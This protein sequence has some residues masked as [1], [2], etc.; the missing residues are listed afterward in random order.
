MAISV[1]KYV[2]ITS[3]VGAGATVAAKDLILRVYTSNTGG[4]VLGDGTS[5]TV[6]VVDVESL[7]EAET[8]FTASSDEY[9][10]ASSYF[11]FKSKFIVSPKKIQFGW[12]EDEAT[13]PD[14]A[15]AITELTAAVEY[16]NNFATF[17]FVEYKSLAYITALAQWNYDTYGNEYHY[18]VA[19]DKTDGTTDVPTA[20]AALGGIGSC[21]F[22]VVDRLAAGPSEDEWDEFFPGAV[23]AATNYNRPNAVNNFMFQQGSYLAKATTDADEELYK[24]N[25]MNFFGLTQANGQNII[26]YQ[27]GFMNGNGSTDIADMGAFSNEQWLRS[28]IVGELITLFLA[29]PTIEASNE[30]RAKVVQALQPVIDLALLNGTFVDG[31]VTSS[32][33]RQFIETLT[34]NENA[35][36]QV[37]NRGYFLDAEVVEELNQGNQMLENKVVYTLVYSSSK[38]VREVNGTHVLV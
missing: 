16:N 30:G 1:S 32:V 14:S 29:L 38:G 18:L 6:R 37:E 35:Y 2:D 17:G 11:G 15:D 36:L 34:N 13:I 26:F 22:T 33:E 5:G 31:V 27:R 19:Y 28:N 7:E 21:S 25:N 12:L 4:G 23:L 10:I 8:L 20:S 24:A 3:G 9:N